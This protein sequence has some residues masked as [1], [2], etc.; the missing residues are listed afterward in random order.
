MVFRL[1]SNYRVIFILILLVMCAT[2]GTLLGV[3]VEHTLTLLSG[4]L[5]SV[6]SLSHSHED[7]IAW[8]LDRVVLE[9]LL[10]SSRQVV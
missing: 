8:W 6:D 3:A 9:V 1:Q 4:L 10:A 7:F 5:R 2:S